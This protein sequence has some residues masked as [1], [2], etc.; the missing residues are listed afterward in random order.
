MY[1]YVPD[2]FFLME[3]KVLKYDDS[4]ITGL[5]AADKDAYIKNMSAYSIVPFKPK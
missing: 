2:I 1:N 4:I 5:T 3:L